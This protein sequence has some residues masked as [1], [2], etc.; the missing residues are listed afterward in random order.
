[1]HVGWLE[2]QIALLARDHAAA[3]AAAERIT[4]ARP[5]WLGFR[6]AGD[7]LRGAANCVDEPGVASDYRARATASY[8][9]AVADLD[10]EVAKHPGDPWFVLP[11]GFAKIGLAEL[12]VARNDAAAARELLAA[13]MPRLAAVRE[14][15]F[16]DEWDDAAFARGDA[17]RL[18]LGAGGTR[19]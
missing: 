10:E 5:T 18:M 16:R 1:V 6:R 11:W 9:R 13:A 2:A 8:E 14:D 17:L 15:A 12:A 19:H 3:A 4:I 7:C